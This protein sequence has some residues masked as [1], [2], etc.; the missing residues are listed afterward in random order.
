[1]SV[2]C[3]V[4]N[5]KMNK[6]VEEAQ[7]FLA[8]LWGR[9]GDS[10]ERAEVVIAPPY[11]ALTAVAAG[12]ARPNAGTPRLRFLAAQNVWGDGD[13]AYTGEISARMLAAVGCRFVIVGHSERRVYIGETDTQIARKIAVACEWGITPILCV[14]ET[15]E[16]R[17]AEQSL[18]VVERQIRAASAALPAGSVIAYEPVW[19]IGTG[20]TPRVDEIETIHQHIRGLLAGLPAEEGSRLLYGGSV[21]CENIASVMS[22]PSVDGVLVGGASLAASTFADLVALGTQAKRGG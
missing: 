18:Q 15:A 13:G 2:P 16:A 8:D 1:M 11:T 12:L 22:L 9:L 10:D 7:A 3:F 6:T 17:R 21:N 19:A 14:G 4:A 5:W 20:V